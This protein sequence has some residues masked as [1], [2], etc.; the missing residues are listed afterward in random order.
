M[1]IRNVRVVA[2]AAAVVAALAVTGCSSDDG[3]KDKGKD[4]ASD[5]S[6]SSAAPDGGASSGG[7]TG[8]AKDAEGIWSATTDGKPVVLVVGGKQASLST[9]DGHLCVGALADM[10]KP[11][12]NLKCADGSTDRTMGAIE[13]NDGTTMKVSWDAGARDTFTKSKDGKLPEGLPSGMPTN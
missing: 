8:S 9:G 11:M 10:G 7:S 1:R 12:L 5:G 4:K 2:G 3:G 13:S 6:S